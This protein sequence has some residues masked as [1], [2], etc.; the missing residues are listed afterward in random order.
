MLSFAK[1]AA[2]LGTVEARRTLRSARV[3]VLLVLFVMFSG[4]VAALTSLMVQG[5]SRAVDDQIAQARP[6]AS[7]SE[8][9]ELKAQFEQ[10]AREGRNEF[11]KLWF[12][13]DAA[14]LEAVQDVPV[15]LLVLFKLSL[16][17]LPLYVALLGFDSVSTE[18]GSRSIRYLAIRTP[19]AAILVGKFLGL[20]VVLL[21]L[22]A[23]TQGLAVAWAALS[24]QDFHATS[25]F[26]AWARFS[27]SSFTYALAWLA[28][29]TLCSSLFRVSM[30]GLVVNGMA[31]FG[32]WLADAVGSGISRAAPGGALE[33]L[34]PL[35]YLSPTHYA[36]DLL[37]PALGRFGLSALACA[38]FAAAFLALGA[39]SLRTRDI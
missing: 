11:L 2:L 29:T 14:L 38:A 24:D 37:H 16:V 28:L 35:R 13:D 25:A 36:G 6:D 7:P 26:V 5:V 21:A 23:G 9:A 27:V 4:L 30:V 22:V 31:M 34:A 3:V 15:A 33:L 19:R 1:D 17:F 12:A 20:A 39:A 10:Q 8:R 18:L 32:L